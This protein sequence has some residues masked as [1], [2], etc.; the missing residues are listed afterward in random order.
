MA[1]YGIGQ[2]IR[3]AEDRRFL[4]GDS[5]FVDD[6]SLDGTLHGVV[7]R[8]PHAHAV[9]RGIDTS[10][11]EAAPGVAAV[12]TGADAAADGLLPVRPHARTAN[13]DG[14]PFF[15]P[16]RHALVSDRVRYLGDGVAFVVAGTREQA[17]DAAEL[18]SVEYEPLPSVVDAETAL[19]DD[20][21][22]IWD[23]PRKNLSYDWEVGDSTAAEAALAAAEHVVSLDLVNH[24]VIANSIEPRG[25]LGAYDESEERYLLYTSGQNIHLARGILADS[26]KM[27][28]ENIRVVAPDVGGGF[29]MKNFLYPETVLVLWAARRLGRPVKWI[30]ERT[31]SFLSDDHGRDHVTRAEL[32]LDADGRFLGL[33]VHTLGNLGAY[34]TA[35]AALLHTVAYGT[36]TG[37]VYDIPAVHL[38]VKAVFTNATPLGA[39]RGVGYAESMNVMERLV[40]AAARETGIDAL[41]LRRRNF[42]RTDAAP[43]TN[44]HGVT[45]DTGTCADT[46]D[47]ALD[48][49]DAA[50]FEARRDRSEAAGRLRGLGV[51]YYMEMTMG[52]PE[53]CVEIR[54]EEDDGVA[55]V[56]G[57]RSNGQ[58]HET[59]FPQIVSAKLGIP[60]ENIVFGQGDTDLIAKGGGH[61]GS[62]S[63]H[64]AGSALH[65]ASESIVEKGRAVAAHALEAAEADI[66]FSEGLF[67]VAGTD[68]ALDILEVARIARDPERRPDGMEAGLDTYQEYWRE[69]STFPNGAH[70][71]EVEVDPDTGR[72]S[73]TRYTIVDDF[74][75]LINPLIASGQVHGGLAQGIGQALME[76]IRFDPENGQMLT[77]TFMDYAVPRADDMPDVD[78]TF[79][80][81]P[82]TTNPLGVKG[83]GEAGAV[84]A[85]PAVTNAVVDALKPYGVTRFDGPATPETV[86]RH[87]RENRPPARGRPAVRTVS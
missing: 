78:L 36:L 83:C 49:A 40:E 26:L 66:E 51:A 60:F 13:T 67:T 84:G 37:G 23:S 42:M 59:T 72:V 21:P 29:G 45:I 34:V 20:A 70:V 1:V 22:A 76:R 30:N 12:L 63:T 10:A 73:L 54:F 55:L 32:G 58:G 24:R 57:T 38:G 86:W 18:V 19:S 71:C 15:V 56:T 9:I 80:E 6:V 77:A 64:M 44:F 81:V 14:T 41:E 61:G 5:R 85:F 87:M 43:V 62:R 65:L 39:Y 17:L 27:P 33:R 31:E 28:A 68:R 25:S 74:G 8:S 7:L 75:V 69:A 82:C 79:N 46:L 35:T 50:G 47:R 3:R 2:A 11:A 52:P 48:R 16:P 53:E 4:T